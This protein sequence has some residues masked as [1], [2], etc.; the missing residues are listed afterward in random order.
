MNKFDHPLFVIFTVIWFIESAV[1]A[2]AGRF[3]E[4]AVRYMPKGGAE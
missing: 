2:V 3:W 4:W 1:L